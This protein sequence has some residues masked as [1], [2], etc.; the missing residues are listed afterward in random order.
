MENS[1][2][3]QL[4][5]AHGGPPLCGI[6]R[7]APEDFV[8]DEDLGFAPDGSGEHVFVRVE[9]RG[10]NTDWVAKELARF[11]G[12][13]PAAVSYSGLKDRHARTRQTFSIHL[14]GKSDPAWE[15]LRHPELSILG[16]ARH[17]R[18]LKRGAHRGNSFEIT[19]REVTGDR[20]AAAGVIAA[21]S[22]CGAPNYFGEQRFGRG[23]AN[24]E[25]AL[26]MFAGRRVARDERSL[27]LSAA[28]SHLFNSVLA[29]RVER[30]DWNRPL[31]GDVWML[32]GTHSIFG[33]EPVSAGL[34]ARCL[35]G[36]I[37]P[38]GPLW[39]SGALRTS[40]EVLRIERATVGRNAELAAGLEAAGLRQERRS[41]VLRPRDLSAEW[42]SATSLKLR[43]YLQSGSYATVIIREISNTDAG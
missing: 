36:D 33:P 13:S 25:K 42:E 29:A 35:A 31:E 3:A 6:L 2:P 38:T 21:I 9:K 7:S 34:A 12:V 8:V 15:A 43:F 16:H 26:R 5:F 14:P 11:A 20:A 27:L 10:A 41:L 17:G 39:G 4:P 24:V 40:G 22:A 18:K 23:G 32:A 37:S 28:R 30:G 1:A 19:L